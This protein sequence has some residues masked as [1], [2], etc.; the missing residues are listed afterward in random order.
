MEGSDV[1]SNKFFL[2]SGIVILIIVVITAS[3]FG[4]YY[5][6][7]PMAGE[8]KPNTNLTQLFSGFGKQFV[9]ALGK[10]ADVTA[11]MICLSCLPNDSF[12]EDCLKN[13]ASF[14]SKNL[15]DIGSG[16]LIWHLKNIYLTKA[17]VFKYDAQAVH[18]LYF[19]VL[20]NMFN[21]KDIEGVCKKNF[22]KSCNQLEPN[23]LVLLQRGFLSGKIPPLETISSDATGSCFQK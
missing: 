8:I 20:A 2:Y 10:S 19:G 4:Y 5:N 9:S 21:E 6:K 11:P 17:I 1:M 15:V 16:E 14:V 3:P 23:E 13:M 7:L 12:S 22:A 18:S